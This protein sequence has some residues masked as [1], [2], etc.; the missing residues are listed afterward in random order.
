MRQYI[1][2]ITLLLFVILSGCG[3]DSNPLTPS[4]NK[5]SVQV[6]YKSFGDTLRGLDTRS[7][8][9][10]TLDYTNSDSIIVYFSYK[11]NKKWNIVSLSG[12]NV[13]TTMVG[14]NS[15]ADSNWHLHRFVDISCKLKNYTI[16][17][18]G[19]GYTNNSQ[20]MIFKDFYVYK[21]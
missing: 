12:D 19:T 13:L 6:I 5:D 1:Y 3:S 7:I 10:G 9:L 17:G 20:Y 21:K 8:E 14:T 15:I 4:G 16:L 18:I 2:V 11:C